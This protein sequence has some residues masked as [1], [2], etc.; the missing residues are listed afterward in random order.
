MRVVTKLRRLVP[1]Q[2]PEEGALTMKLSKLGK[3]QRRL[4]DLYRQRVAAR[5]VAAQQHLWN[6]CRRTARNIL[7]DI[8][9]CS[10]WTCVLVPEVAQ[11]DEL[12]HSVRSEVQAL[13]KSV[14]AEREKAWKDKII[15]DWSHGG[16]DTYK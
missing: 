11:L 15:E 6:I 3:L 10:L 2:L 1:P 4:S 8:A 7:Q 5:P 12:L 13:Q 14:R 16:S 9:G